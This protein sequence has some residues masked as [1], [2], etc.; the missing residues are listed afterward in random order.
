[1]K[2]STSFKRM[3]LVSAIVL[4]AAT[5]H[6]D[7]DSYFT[8]GLND[9]VRISPSR[10]GGSVGVSVHCVSQGRFDYWYMTMSLAGGLTTQSASP[11]QDMIVPF[12]NS[13][14][15][16][17]CLTA[18]LH[19]SNLFSQVFAI[20]W[21]EITEPGFWDSNNDGTYESYGTVKWEA[22]TYNDM[23]SLL[24]NVPQNFTGGQITIDGHFDSG[25]DMRGGTTGHLTF[26][27]EVEFIIGYRLGDVNS[28]DQ[29]S[30]VDLTMLTDYLLS[31]GSYPYLDPYQLDAAD[32]NRDGQVS[33]LDVSILTDMLI[34]PTSSPGTEELTE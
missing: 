23:F 29:I 11:G 20:F 30:I 15:I 13:S 5:A 12:I 34:G 28:D 1:M 8:M 27:K 2:I 26:Y 6:A 21:S 3:M 16:D 22:G 25:I 18:Q 14:G 4:T 24:L 9:T 31:G 19:Y 32:I 7:M 10:L 17:T 33:I